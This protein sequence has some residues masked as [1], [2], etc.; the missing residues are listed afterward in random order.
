L[1]KLMMWLYLHNIKDAE[2]WS[3]SIFLVIK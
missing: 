1:Q 2:E 3:P